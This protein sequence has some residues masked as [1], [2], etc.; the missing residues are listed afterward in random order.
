MSEPTNKDRARWAKKA[1]AAFT[2]QTFGRHP[3]KMHPDDLECAISDLICDLLHF[4]HQSGFDPKGRLNAA[5][6]HFDAEIFEEGVQ[7]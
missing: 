4:A 5:E 7:L 1:L 3:D 2:K 6:M